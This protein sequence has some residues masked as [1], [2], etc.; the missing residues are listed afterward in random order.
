MLPEWELLTRCL[1]AASLYA[2]ASLQEAEAAEATRLKASRVL[3]SLPVEQYLSRLAYFDVELQA[4]A[5]REDD[6]AAARAFVAILKLQRENIYPEDAFGIIKPEISAE[7]AFGNR[8][9]SRAAGL[10]KAR[11]R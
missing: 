10:P 3:S 6:E 5:K 9:A 4:S 2:E 7:M 11:V 8:A 1:F